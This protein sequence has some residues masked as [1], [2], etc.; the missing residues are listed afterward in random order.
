MYLW[1]VDA[2]GTRPPERLEVAGSAGDPAVALT[3]DGLAFVRDLFDLDIYRFEVG[4]PAQVVI[5]SNAI[6]NEPRLSPDGRRLAFET[7]RSGSTGEIW[8]ADADGSNPQPLTHGMAGFHGSPYWSPDGRRIVFDSMDDDLH[9]HIWIIDADGGSPRRLTT[10]TDN[11]HAPAWS[12]DGRWIYFSSVQ[13]G[14][15]RDLWRVSAD[16]RTSERLIRG[17]SGPF[18]CETVD[19]KTLLFQPKGADS[20]LMAMPL[21]GGAARQLVACVKST[22]FGVA[23]QGVYYVPCDSSPNPSVHVLD[24][25]TGSDLRLGTLEGLGGPPM[26]LAV[27][28]DGSTI[29]YPRIT[30]QNSDLMLIENFR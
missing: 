17:A 21:S 3:R 7:A 15:A 19:G 28:P 22:A 5:G 4:S 26:G 25:R 9:Y 27:S 14:A 23:S 24:L 12:R 18:A 10:Q 16:G 13:G 6:E 30:N 8:V 1:R 2:D 29:L 11:E 20:P